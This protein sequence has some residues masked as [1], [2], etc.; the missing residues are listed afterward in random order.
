MGWSVVNL[1]NML[2]W[3]RLAAMPLSVWCILNNQLDTAFIIFVAAGVT[4]ALD[5]FLARRLDLV[6]DFG[7]VIDPVADKALLVATY[8]A[9]A[10]SGY[11]P[12]WLAVLVVG[13]DIAIVAAYGV[14]GLFGVKI[15]PA[16]VLM[17]KFNTACQIS[18]AA[19]VLFQAGMEID[20][21][22][23]IPVLVYLTAATTTISWVQY[24]VLWITTR[25]TMQRT[26]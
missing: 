14:S 23:I 15:R 7:R 1:P 22:G 17:S 13:R 5:G 6:S 9:L 26:G 20:L 2:S 4:D 11:L 16:P 24:F 19:G 8:V 12:V 21:W 10:Y 25:G 18:L 3:A